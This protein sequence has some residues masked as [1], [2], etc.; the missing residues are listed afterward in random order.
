M[1]FENL[2][3]I[4]SDEQDTLEEDILDTS[5]NEELDDDSMEPPEDY[6][7]LVEDEPEEEFV[8]VNTEEIGIFKI[9]ENMPEELKQQLTKFNAKA[10]AINGIIN[11]TDEDL[12]RQDEELAREDMANVPEIPE[13]D[14]EESSDGDNSSSDDIIE[15]DSNVEVGNLF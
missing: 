7:P 11:G 4:Q 2:N 14:G 6:S 8:E 9:D 1:D 13:E 15:E 12:V 10:Q 5:G 3:E